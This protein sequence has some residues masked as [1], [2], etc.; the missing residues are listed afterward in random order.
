MQVNFLV[1]PAKKDNIAISP[2]KGN[3]EL[4]HYIYNDICQIPPKITG[5]FVH[6]IYNDICDF[7]I[8]SYYNEISFEFDQR[9][10]WEDNTE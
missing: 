2:S 4:A 9:L 6:Y 7:K 5:E 10:P 3:C 8:F 1:G